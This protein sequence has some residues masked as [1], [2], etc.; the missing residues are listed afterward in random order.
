MGHTMRNLLL[1]VA[2]VAIGC[3]FATYAN[4]ANVAEVYQAALDNDPVLGAAK[5]DYAARGEIVPQARAGLLPNVNLNATTSYNR[6]EYPKGVTVDTNPSSPTFGQLRG[7]PGDEFND[8][9]WQ[10]QLVQ[11]LVDV[12]AYYTYKSSQA[13]KAQ[14][15]QD[16]TA[17]EQSLIVRSVSAYLDILR[18]QAALE[19]ITAQEA[20]VKRQQEQVQQRFDVGLV[21]ITDVLDATAAYDNVVVQRIQAERDQGIEFETLYTLTGTSYQEVDQISTTLPIV[22]PASIDEDEWVTIALANNPNIL[23]SREAKTAADRDLRAK[24]AAFLP[25]VDGILSYNQDINHVET[26]IGGQGFLGDKT[27]TRTYALQLQLPIYQGGFTL[28]KVRESRARLLQSDELLRNSEWT[29]SRDIR[30]LLR[31][32]IT[33]VI[34]VRARI[35]SIKSAESALEATQTGY[36]VG[37]RNIVDVL[38]AQQRLY[39]SQ[40][41]YADARYSYVRDLFL[42][43]QT[44]G[45]LSP[46]DVARLNAYVDPQQPIRKL[47]AITDNGQVQ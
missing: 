25:T 43:K 1:T 34:R 45:T 17:S 37:T 9:T 27:N 16:F 35:K 41:D 5:Q 21:A 38:N 8:H 42:L 26:F 10:A 33:D 32:V 36:E 20:A 22:N 6:L 28:S 4:A 19:S 23:S 24:Q 47:N 46:D 18:S 44:A 14:A 31:A 13:L 30:N 7:I 39:A 11:P 2:A 40:F 15:K 3:A 12:A 29:V